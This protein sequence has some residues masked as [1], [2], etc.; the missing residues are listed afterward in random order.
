MKRILIRAD[1]LGYSEGVN[2]GIAKSMLDGVI[3]SVGLMSNMPA[4]EHGVQLLKGHDFCLG[5]HTNICAGAPL[6][7]PEQ[8]PSLVDEDGNF[9]TSKVYRN[10]ERDFV[11]L[12]EAVLEVEAQYQRF[13]E[14]TGQQP[15]HFGSHA[16]KSENFFRAVEIVADRH[17][18]P[19]LGSSLKGGPILF[20][21]TKLY[22]AM[23]S[24]KPG[25][26][27]F[28]S[29]KQAA[30]KEYGEDGCCMFICHPGYLDEEI[31]RA[32][33]LTRSRPMEVAMSI[34]PATKQWLEENQIRL[35]TFSDLL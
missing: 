24:M 33:S 26:D 21:H 10:A 20:R 12:E 7:D 34:S 11:V 3:R 5:Q 29:L 2:Y 13:V 9:K 16:V 35:V 23:D 30:L 22:P 17:D 6:S 18:L 15:Q 32:S 25:Y 27:P 14:L 4:A 28:E 31:L 1:D 19:F 8:V